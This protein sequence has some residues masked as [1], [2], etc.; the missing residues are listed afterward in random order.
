MQKIKLICIATITL[1]EMALAAELTT[2]LPPSLW[3]ASDHNN[4]VA[5][6]PAVG[7]SALP[8]P[9][10]GAAQWFLAPNGTQPPSRNVYAFIYHPNSGGWN[11]Y[12]N[13]EFSGTNNKWRLGKVCKTSPSDP[14]QRQASKTMAPWINTPWVWTHC[15]RRPA[16]RSFS[17]R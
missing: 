4:Q 16:R 1:W 9:S 7:S 8:Q 10:W 15:P 12:I 3:I 17:M 14:P 5:I 13:S 2:P 11:N 6:G